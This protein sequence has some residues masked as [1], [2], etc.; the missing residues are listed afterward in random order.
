MNNKERD[1]VLRE[2]GG[3]AKHS[4]NAELIGILGTAAADDLKRLRKQRKKLRSEV[5]RLKESY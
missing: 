3:L 1:V 5:A 2:L 4:Y